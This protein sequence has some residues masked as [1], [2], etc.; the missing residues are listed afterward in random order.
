M[1]ACLNG[2]TDGEWQRTDRPPRPYPWTKLVVPSTGSMIH[3]GLSVRMHASP[4]ATDSSPMKLQ[5]RITIT[6]T[7]TTS[8]G[9]QQPIWCV[10]HQW[11]P[12]PNSS[13]SEPMMIFST[14]SS[15][16]VTRSTVELFVMTFISLSPA[17]LMTYTNTYYWHMIGNQY[18]I[19]W[20][21]P[22]VL[23]FWR[24]N[25]NT[26]KD[27]DALTNL[28]SLSRHFN[29]EVVRLLPGVLH[30]VVLVSSQNRAYSMN[31]D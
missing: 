18:V 25:S 6:S 22:S 5:P 14:L 1:E 30:V 21:S 7:S 16:L 24:L 19:F 28:S 4:F 29:C 10:S 17:F 15:V 26:N 11:V 3:V 20:S 8:A 2:G 27:S 31:K 23:R 12:S 13:F 9:L